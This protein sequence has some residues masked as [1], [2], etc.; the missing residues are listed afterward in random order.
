[1]S[2]RVSTK[3]Q[4]A[5]LQRQMKAAL[6]AQEVAN[7]AFIAMAEQGL[8]SEEVAIEHANA[9]PEVKEGE[10]L[11]NGALRKVDGELVK[12]VVK[13]IPMVGKKPAHTETSFE[14]VEKAK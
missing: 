13:E 5:H 11:T 6:S 2:I 4:L 10:V 12:V 9:F 3:E 1:M 7:L 8:I 14:A